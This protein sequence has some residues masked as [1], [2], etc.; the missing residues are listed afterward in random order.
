MESWASMQ[1]L[2]AEDFVEGFVEYL[3][4]DFGRK[5]YEYFQKNITLFPEIGTFIATLPLFD[6]VIL[7]IV[8]IYVKIQKKLQKLNNFQTWLAEEL[9]RIL[10]V[11]TH[12]TLS[13]IHLLS[14][15]YDISTFWLRQYNIV[16]ISLFA[17]V[18]PMVSVSVH[19]V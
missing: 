12:S 13:N 14:V 8:A 9:Y 15:I 3:K 6:A 5:L 1:A 11:H 10:C 18:Y 16:T 4:L 17:N 19:N 2:L 7:C